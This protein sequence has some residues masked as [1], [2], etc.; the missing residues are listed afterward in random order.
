MNQAD[1][2]G[3]E[4]VFL[5][6]L[7]RGPETAE[8]YLVEVCRGDKALE[9][10]VRLLLDAHEKADGFLV[11]PSDVTAGR[12][13]LRPDSAI[14]GQRI[15]PYTVRR[16]VASG[17]MGVVYEA[18]Q[19]RPHRTVALKVMRAGIASA[20]ALRRF[21]YESQ[22]L[23]RL[24]HPNI[25]QVYEAGT[26]EEPGPPGLTI[27][28]FAMEYIPDAR[29]LI[30]FAD[31]KNLSNRER[32]EL[33]IT[34]CQA[35]HHGHQKGVIHRDL[36]P[37]NILVDSAG[38]PKI[39]DFG[40]AR[41]TDSDMAVT[42]FQTDVGQ[43]IGTLQYMSPEQC[44]ADPHDLDSRSDVYALG[45]VLYELLCGRPPYDLSH[46]AVHEAARVIRHEPPA[47]PSTVNRALRGDLET[48]AL[49]ALEKDRA[50]RY[51]ST[52]DLAADLERYLRDQ[53]IV[54]RPPSVR[55]Q[56]TKFVRRNK[57]LVSAAVLAV[58]ALVLGTAVATWQAVRANE[59]ASRAVQI[60]EFLAS[61]LGAT[62]FAE[63]GRRLSAEEILDHALDG[64]ETKFADEP[65]IEAEIRHIAGLSSASM[66]RFAEAIEQLRSA[67]DVRGRRLGD[68]H[69]DTLESA[70]SLGRVLWQ[71]GQLGEAEE[72]LQW[73]VQTRARTLGEDHEDTLWSMARLA[74]VLAW[75]GKVEEAQ[76]LGGRA[77]AGLTSALG[78]EHE[79]TL[80]AMSN[81][82]AIL[83][84]NN[85]LTEAEKLARK[86]LVTARRELGEEHW[87]TIEVT[88][89]L[90]A[91]L[92]LQGQWEESEPLARSSLDARRRLFGPGD[93]YA[94]IWTELLGWAL[95][96]NG[97]LAEGEQMIRRGVKGLRRVLGVRNLNTIYAVQ[98]LAFL[99]RDL[100]RHAEAEDLLQQCIDVQRDVLGAKH[101]YTIETMRDLA[102]WLMEGGPEQLANAEALAR[103]AVDLARSAFAEDDMLT[104][105]ATATHGRCLLD[106]Q[107]FDDAESVLEGAYAGFKDL[108]GEHDESTHA[109]LEDL[110]GLYN[111]WGR[112][113]KAAE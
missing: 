95:Y 43:L 93:S 10:Q 111:A 40:V 26:H 34:V 2:D 45:V 25:A 103:E 49:K 44:E 27:P 80:K 102:T 19:E 104:L 94:L 75:V 61:T 91:F 62:D 87:L 4:K 54:A 38:I 50:R 48:I 55:Y 86:T 42:T 92:Y 37:G 64:I 12:P 14:Q 96:Q 100:G 97:E 70:H 85:K 36:K 78:E 8:A 79:Q 13:G 56:L 47:R 63:A 24:R 31:E 108:N 41:A 20:S 105:T 72:L 81:Q 99:E 33:F 39:I 16:V 57:A 3:I 90:G 82:S 46:V 67:M 60:K 51:Q 74:R 66:S 17:G 76:R 101:R 71:D 9:T 109:V 30:E 89:N 65:E 73:V 84:I 11:A 15:G 107:R 106:L 1:N 23:A 6:A 58:A 77:V 68:E 52:S 88:W 59:E 22:I 29:P 32:L 5:G 28:Y 69:P 21:E 113:Q 110:I 53:P 98:R 7:Q 18:V 35:V 83:R 112:P